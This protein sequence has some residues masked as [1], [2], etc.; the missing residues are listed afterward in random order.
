MSAPI[1]SRFDRFFVVLDERRESTDL[2]LAWHIVGVH[3]DPEGSVQPELSTKALHRYVRYVRTYSPKFTPGAV[4]L[5]AEKHRLLRQSDATGVGENSEAIAGANCTI[6]IVPPF[7]NEA[8]LLLKSS[9]IHVQQDNSDLDDADLDMNV[10]AAAVAAD[11]AEACD[12]SLA[13]PS[14]PIPHRNGSTPHQLAATLQLQ[15]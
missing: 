11:A 8:Y 6:K 9:I 1:M 2:M 10:N 5:L 14:S 7:V 12:E 15:P 13:M 4:D 3:A